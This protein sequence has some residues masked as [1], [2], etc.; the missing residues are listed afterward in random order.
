MSDVCCVNLQSVPVC[1]VKSKGAS[2]AGL[3]VRYYLIT[4]SDKSRETAGDA[5]F[6]RLNRS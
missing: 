4:G 2:E 1:T 6:T 3:S 5:F